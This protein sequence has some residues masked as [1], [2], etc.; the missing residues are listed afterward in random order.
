MKSFLRVALC[1]VALSS[2]AQTPVRLSWQEFAKDPNRVQ[3]FRNA[4]AKMKSRNSLDPASVEFRKS[5]TY[6][7][8]MHGYFGDD[9]VNGTVAKWRACNNLSGPE[10][11]AAFEGVENTSPPD[12]VAKTV[13]DQCQHRTNYFFA[14]H[15]LFLYYFERVLQ[16]AAGDPSLRLPYWDYT[17]P[18]QLAM[19]AEF[20]QPT[21][22]N[23]AGQTFD[24]P[25]YEKR[26]EPGWEPGTTTLDEGDTDIDLALD[27]PNFLTTNDAAGDEV[28]GYQ[29]TIESSPHGYVHCA[30]MGCRATVMGAVPYSSNDPIFWIHHCNIDRI[31]ECWLSKGNK[32]PASLMGRSFSYVDENGKLVKKYVRNLF[33]NSLIDYVYQQ[34]SNCERKKTP[35]VAAMTPASADTLKS[36]KAA[37]AKPVVIGEAKA[38]ALRTA[39]SSKRV[40]LPATA[41]PAHPRQFA[42][43]EQAQLP[44]AT[45]MVLRRIRF[46]VHPRTGFRIYL[47]RADD[48]S[49]R[50]Y[51]ATL[52]FF[53]DGTDHHSSVADTRV[54]DV[55]KELRALGFEGTGALE[56]DVVFEAIDARERQGFNPAA[57]KV[58]VEEIEFRVK[59]DL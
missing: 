15:R 52:S 47:Q 11:D 29:S 24:N 20:R 13:W 53:A 38:H 36:A 6:W 44:V 43:Q 22:V 31:W 4:V 45:E 10:Y 23:A 58:T 18:A 30:V 59:Q 54:F 49:R 50:A 19:P 12:D 8:N 5:W 35:S 33:D 25:L 16:D 32:T 2:F 55:T 37:L 9:A 3:S 26:R 40:S 39:V 27:N 28:P 21:Y 42:L 14:W 56:V 57:T 1:F 41:S 48:P 34:G 7:A 46:D 51:V 17:D